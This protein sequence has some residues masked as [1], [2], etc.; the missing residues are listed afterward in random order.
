[1][2][3]GSSKHYIVTSLFFVLHVKSNNNGKSTQVFNPSPFQAS[4][5]S[6]KGQK[7][8]HGTQLYSRIHMR[9]MQ[10]QAILLAIVVFIS[11]G[12]LVIK[13]VLGMRDKLYSHKQKQFVEWN[14]Y[15]IDDDSE[16]VVSYCYVNAL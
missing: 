11:L 16:S 4:L 6:V 2:H 14:S 1:M 15:R 5:L 10:V 8:L 12:C 7:R 13:I 3:I 9:Y